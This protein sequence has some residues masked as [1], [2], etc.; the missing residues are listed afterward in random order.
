[1]KLTCISSQRYKT[2]LEFIHQ[3]KSSLSRRDQVVINRLRIGHTR[4]THSYLLTGADQPECTTCQC[5]LTVDVSST[6]LLIVLILTILATN[7]SLL[8]LWRNYSELRTYITSL[9]LQKKLI[10][11]ASYDV[12]KHF[13][14]SYLALILW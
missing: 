10:F 14:S 4:C 12:Y 9:I 7:I 8:P 5:P 13:Y 1:M 2:T 6:S 3:P 11:T